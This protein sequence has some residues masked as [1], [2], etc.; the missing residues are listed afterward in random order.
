MDSPKADMLP[1]ASAGPSPHE[2][3]S[4][5]FLARLRSLFTV[6]RLLSKC[7]DEDDICRNAVL[8]GRERLGFDRLGVWLFAGDSPLL[9]GTFGTGED[10]SLRDERGFEYTGRMD[11][12]TKPFRE[13][14]EPLAA[15]P[16]VTLDN[17][18]G[19]VVG[20]GEHVVAALW[21][22][23]RAL[24]VL[25]ADNLFS[26]TPM[27]AEQREVMILLASAIGHQILAARAALARREQ[28][29]RFQTVVE[30]LAE[31]IVITDLDGTTRYVNGKLAE[32]SGYSANELVGEKIYHMVLSP[33]MWP[34]WSAAIERRKLGVSETYTLDIVRKEGTARTVQV[35]AS[36][37]RTAHGEVIGTVGAVSDVTE[38]VATQAA[39]RQ[40]QARMAALLRASP[41]IM[42]VSD[43]HGTYL[44]VFTQNPAD[45]LVPV[46]EIIG[47]SIVDILPRDTSQRILELH[48]RVQETG[49]MQT[50]DYRHDIDGV[51]RHFEARCTKLDEDR[52]LSVVRD[53]TDRV[54]AVGDL[55]AN[56]DLML[57]AEPLAK[58]GSWQ[59]DLATS[60]VRWSNGMYGLFD[61]DPAQGVPSQE[62]FQALIHPTDLA[63]MLDALK[64]A[65]NLGTPYALDTRVVL[66]NGTQKYMHVL[67]QAVSDTGGKVMSLFGTVLD[68]TERVHAEASIRENQ[69]LMAAAEPLAKFGS[70]HF[71]VATSN[72]R[73]SNGMYGLF[74]FDPAL[75]MP[76]MEDIQCRIHPADLPSLSRAIE[77]SHLYGRSYTDN[78]RLVMPDGRVKYTHAYGQVTRDAEG[79][80]TETFGT[81][82]DI[83]DRIQATA[84]IER[85]RD[86]LLNAER[87]ARL[88]SWQFDLTT[89]QITWSHEIFKMHGLDP[90]AGPPSF[91]DYQKLIHPADWP[92]LDDAIRAASTFGTPYEM[93]LRNVHPNGCVRV[94]HARGQA[95]LGA[96]GEVTLLFGTLLDITDR[97]YA[98][99]KLGVQRQILHAI[100][101]GEPLSDVLTALTARIDELLP[102]AITSVLLLDESRTR[103]MDGIAPRLPD[104]Y[105]DAINGVEIGPMVGS[106]GAA[107]SLGERVIVTNIAT[108][109]NWTHFKD[110]A[111]KA[112]LA[113]CWSEP[114]KS[115]DDTVLG[116]FAVYYRE[117]RGPE[118]HELEVL[119]TATQLA[120][121]AIERSRA[122][123]AV[124][125][126]EALYRRAI[127]TADGVVYQLDI[128]SNRYTYIDAKI[129][130]LT[131][132]GIDE[133]TPDLL[134]DISVSHRLVGEIEGLPTSEAV[135]RFW[136]G[137]FKFWRADEKWR[138]RDGTEI[139]VSDSS[140]P[141][142]G[143][144]G[145]VTGSIGILQDI[146]VR[147]EAENAIRESENRYRAIFD[148]SPNAIFLSDRDL[149][150]TMTNRHGAETF[151]FS[152][153]SE[154]IGIHAATLIDEGD[155]ERCL[156]YLSM[157]VKGEA[158]S[159]K[160]FI[161]RRHDETTFWGEAAGA[162]IQA[163]S[164]EATGLLIVLRNV[165]ERKRLEE[166]QN[167]SH[168]LE[169][170]GR[171]AG[172]VA[173]DFN[174][175]L[176]VIV[177]FAELAE[178][179]APENSQIT[180]YLQNILTAGQRA[181]DLTSQL[182]TY[183]RKQV[184]SPTAVDVPGV[185]SE[186]LSLTNR[187]IGA[188]ITIETGLDP[189]IRMAKVDEGQFQ[190]VLLN[191]LLNSRD[192]MPEGGRITL[193]AGNRTLDTARQSL[194]PGEYVEITVADTGLG[195][196]AIDAS[197][198]FEPFYTSKRAGSGTGLGLSTC[199]G[200]VRQSGGHISFVSSPGEGATFTVLL[201][202]AEV[203]QPRQQI[204]PAGRA[205][206]VGQGAILV[207]EDEPMVR[208][209]AS[210][211]LTKAGFQ[212]FE[213]GSAEE[214]LEAVNASGADLRLVITDVVL[215]GMNGTMLA[216]ELLELFPNLR[217]I[218]T[219]GY[220]GMRSMES[221]TADGTVAFLPKPFRGGELV[222]KVRE[223]LEGE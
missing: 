42:F 112:G 102:T 202:C 62:Q 125:A 169:S 33:D 113:A 177:G 165:T 132:Y 99:Q 153:P 168:R 199:D 217:I 36:P 3:A 86:L 210:K 21:D 111:A 91:E 32:I 10:G 174:N 76:S 211:A 73:W 68:V 123:E 54:K 146:T 188:N 11:F 143:Q 25:S 5:E 203:S 136:N 194:P 47:K 214:A 204:S 23:T 15:F 135:K 24:G 137:E 157:L 30:G 120:S 181:G 172:G 124:A 167:Q 95:I 60:T 72:L 1:T 29:L 66:R 147:V 79:R 200:I 80:V 209:V 97:K 103:L 20:S 171:L 151:G 144:D 191:L 89:Q 6:E 205:A 51:E 215:P 207:V 206:E 90:A 61:L 170:I 4:P 196:D 26:G 59:F 159:S 77:E 162:A 64:A 12:L 212:V 38:Q 197:H 133:I 16:G 14:E 148:A 182:L 220:T 223:V 7:N 17:H 166:E 67:G 155:R 9:V 107:A 140:I 83:S 27:S 173:H 100:A 163:G 104:F 31:G 108:H 179:T 39:L 160:E 93:D 114:I 116:T 185:I 87:L 154:M 138:K 129:V 110:I 149:K 55:S 45:L 130:T 40:S 192:A 43:V 65:Q 57:A 175:L 82:L 186:T 50:M 98:E 109:P 71:D 106:C 105:N 22:G 81:V 193:R 127:S 48:K 218:L 208:S 58:F 121:I 189:D 134:A 119:D 52:L 219:S 141:V 222:E 2:V 75:G 117:P 8:L 195:I 176:T 49:A 35:T 190:Q 145:K 18:A 85:S 118:A 70:W 96:A 78:S 187:L 183:A 13:N 213:A 56:Q 44:D 158:V 178:E 88:G 180:E 156:G 28:D 221:L 128:P 34:V 139:W 150:I 164:G 46:E 69:E 63:M 142:K 216:A 198:V 74:E 41:D 92:A 19:D 84:E 152:D 131:G 201:P 37:L 161:G 53:I 115:A 101:S 94:G 184:I 126:R 122:V